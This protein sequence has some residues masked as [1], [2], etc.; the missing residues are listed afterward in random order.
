MIYDAFILIIINAIFFVFGWIFCD[1]ILLKERKVNNKLV[2]ATF[3]LTISLTCIMFG[4]VILE[5]LDWFNISIRHFY[6]Y[7]SVVLLLFLLMFIIPYW[8]M[9]LFTIMIFG[10]KVGNNPKMHMLKAILFFISSYIFWNSGY[11]YILDKKHD[12]FSIFSIEHGNNY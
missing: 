9:H 2:L 12:N 8:I 4:I 11:P 3:S 6:W 1:I 7:I 5:I 10:N